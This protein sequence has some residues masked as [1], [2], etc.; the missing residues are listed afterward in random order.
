M[1]RFTITGNSVALDANGLADDVGAVTPGTTLFV[2]AATT[3]SDGLSHKLTITPSGS[4]TGSYVITG[5][6]P[7]GEAQSETLAT[8]TVNAV[9]SA[10]Y[11]LSVTSVKSPAGL[12]SETVDIGW[13]AASVSP[14][15]YL[16]PIGEFGPAGMGFAC[17]VDSGSP[18]YSVQ[19]T[20]D[21]GVTAF[22]HADVT[23]ETTSQA[24]TILTPVQAV[25]L[26]WTVAGEVTMHGLF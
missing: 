9:T 17:I 13:A 6:G 18:T 4:V 20:L 26:S 11:Y 15:E 1:N 21:G 16:D 19:Y 24:G 25:R 23:G 2:L 3:I 12:G 7:D 22:T 5:L 14:W 10:K 8:D